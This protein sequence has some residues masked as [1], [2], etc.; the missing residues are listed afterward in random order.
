MM[1]YLPAKEDLS[2]IRISLKVI[3]CH[4]VRREKYL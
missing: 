1:A 4:F 3:P 2:G